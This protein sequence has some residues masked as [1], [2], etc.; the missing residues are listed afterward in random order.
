MSD[1]TVRITL[2]SGNNVDL[3]AEVYDKCLCEFDEIKYVSFSNMIN[4]GLYFPQLMQFILVM[5]YIFKGN[6]SF[7]DIFLCNLVNGIWFTVCWYWLRLHK[8]A[9]INLISSL[10]GRYILRLNIHFIVIAAVSLFVIGDWKVILYC[11]A[12]GL[13]T[14]MIK[15]FLYNKFSSVKYH[16]EVAIYVSK[17]HS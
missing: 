7:K 6:T 13:V 2:A 14:G 17:F 5:I 11:L 3:S 1:E 9:F 15:I 4:N 12:G 16:D 10:I 8:L